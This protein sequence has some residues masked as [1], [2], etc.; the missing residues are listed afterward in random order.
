[1]KSMTGY[2][3]ARSGS[4]EVDLEVTVRA[5]NGRFLEL[6]TQLPPHYAFLESEIKSVVGQLFKRGRVDLTIRRRPG[7]R[8]STLKVQ[9]QSDLARQWIEGYKQLGRDL[10]LLAEPNLDM[11][12]R[13]PDVI[14]FE[15]RTDI[16]TQEK[17]LVLDTVMKAVKNCD[18]E[19]LREGQALSRE[20]NSLLVNLKRHVEKIF[21]FREQA[22]KALQKKFRERLSKLELENLVSE[23][24]MMQEIAVQIERADITEEIVR[25]KEHVR[26]FSTLID[27][28]EGQGKKLDFY[29]QELLREV[30]TIG[31]KSQLAPLT[32]LV[33]DSKSIVEQIREQVQNVE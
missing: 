23:P 3:N 29:T 4:E 27:S 5:V 16:S 9:V 24:R 30:N 15:E 26:V 13:L 6:R 33:V 12:A 2:G 17:R 22:T 10:R 11:V 31:S 28:N 14:H 20:L 25:L 7:V 19:R 18:Q 1:M 8:A 21:R 32:K